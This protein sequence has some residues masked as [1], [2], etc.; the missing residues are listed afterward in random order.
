MN[1]IPLFD[2]PEK[3]AERP[4]IFDNGEALRY[5]WLETRSRVRARQLL[6][7]RS[8]LDEARIGFL[9]EPGFEYVVTQWAIWR[10]GGI[11]VPLCPAHPQR[12]LEYVID[13]ADV[14]MLLASRGLHAKLHPLAEAR[15]LPYRRVA[16]RGYDVFPILP[17]L[18]EEERARAVAV[19]EAKDLPQLS[20]DRR[21]MILYTSGTTGRPKG[22]VTTHANIDAHM[23]ALVEAWEWQPT[24]RILHV[25]PLHHTHGI[26][27][28]LC[29]ALYAGASVEFALSF[30][31]AATWDRLASP[32]VT[33]FMAVPTIYAKLLRE[34]EKADAFTRRRW[35][36]GAGELRL[37]VSGSAALPVTLFDRWQ[38]ITGHRLL[39]RYGMTE[40]GMGL[41]NPFFGERR[42]GTVGQPLPSVEMR[43]VDAESRAILAEGVKPLADE[44]SGEILVRGPMVF[45]EYWRRPEETAEAFEEG[46]F[47]TGDEATLQDGYYRILGR[48]SVDIL[49]S[50]GYKIS[51]IEIE[52]LLRSHPAVRDC[53]VVGLPDEEWGERIAA[54]V[55]AEPGAE[56]IPDLTSAGLAGAEERSRSVERVLDP[57]ARERLAP[58]KVPRRWLCVEELPR[59]AMGKVQKPLVKELFSKGAK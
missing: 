47:R 29:C 46:W 50:G 30:D 52:E 43:V 9:M 59:N 35:S 26:V 25:L 40:I 57:W 34:W 58:Y 36:R 15:E 41:S 38:E 28:A 7:D 56:L 12:E 19:A 18:A 53:A 48:N 37:M 16:A 21:A 39:E 11:A 13:D 33:V 32:E 8:D 23:R 2:R 20:I 55:V 42:S 27:N 24:D 49:K 5:D 17:L 45:S 22:V 44:V 1:E 54:A 3:F 31:A 51:A 4:A 10:A 6:G 14:A